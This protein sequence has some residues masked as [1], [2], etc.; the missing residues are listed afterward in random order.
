MKKFEKDM[1]IDKFVNS[2]WGGL[3]ITIVCVAIFM[4][5]VSGIGTLIFG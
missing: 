4:L 2:F 1:M 3:I 5:I